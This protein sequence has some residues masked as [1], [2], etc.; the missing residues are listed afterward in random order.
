MLQKME[1]NI[2]IANIQNHI[3]VLAGAGIT[4]LCTSTAACQY[5]HQ[6]VA[7]VKSY[8]HYH[9]SSQVQGHIQ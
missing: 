4:A 5:I 6:Y 3:S 1:R 2:V 9:L 7:T 8:S